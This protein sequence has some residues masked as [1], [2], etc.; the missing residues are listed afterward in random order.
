M[1]ETNKPRDN[2]N[3]IIGERTAL[4]RTDKGIILLEIIWQRKHWW[5]LW[6]PAIK[7]QYA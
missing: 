4:I 1:I 7:A 6:S 3:V 2:V 5:S